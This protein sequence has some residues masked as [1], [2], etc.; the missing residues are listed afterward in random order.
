MHALIPYLGGNTTSTLSYEQRK[1]SQA[2]ATPVGEAPAAYYYVFPPP[3]SSSIDLHTRLGS[4][5]ASQSTSVRIADV[6][7]LSKSAIPNVVSELDTS[8]NPTDAN[9]LDESASARVPRTSVQI[10]SD[11]NEPNASAST[12]P[13]MT[14]DITSQDTLVSCC[15]TKFVATPTDSDDNS[16]WSSTEMPALTS[17]SAGKTIRSHCYDRI[18]LLPLRWGR[19]LMATLQPDTKSVSFTMSDTKSD[20]FT[21]SDTKSDST[22]KELKSND[23]TLRVRSSRRSPPCG[24]VGCGGSRHI[25]FLTNFTEDSCGNTESAA[26]NRDEVYAIVHGAAFRFAETPKHGHTHPNRNAKQIFG[27]VHQEHS[28]LTAIQFACHK[29]FF[30]ASIVSCNNNF[31]DMF[32][33]NNIVVFVVTKFHL[34][35]I[36][37]SFST[38]N[39]MVVFVVTKCIL[40][41]ITSSLFIK[42][43]MV[44]VVVT[45][46]HLKKII[47]SLFIKNNKVV[48]VVT[49]FHLKTIISSWLIKNNEIV[50][51]VIMFQLKKIISSCLIDVNELNTSA[52]SMVQSKVAGS[53]S[54]DGVDTQADMKNTSEAAA[55]SVGEAPLSGDVTDTIVCEKCSATQVRSDNFCG[56]CGV[57]LAQC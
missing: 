57:S 8:A 44:V 6:S 7:A 3:T 22:C 41:T 1:A 54:D 24:Q 51:M 45:K 39:N 55:T 20:C 23:H 28:S 4:G 43:N 14:G 30:L 36:I 46:F 56:N 13:H 32:I 9:E 38:K 27:H 40:K 52:S 2:A 12:T 49:R 19:H 48:F 29:H 33:K 50:F 21:E 47:S 25:T 17:S 10:V 53:I 26:I 37:S 18:R 16:S 15:F 5:N 42:Y 35:T 11:V 34:K 31:A